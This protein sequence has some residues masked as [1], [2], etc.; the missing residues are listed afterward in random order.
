MN[1]SLAQGN[2]A[3]LK[4]DSRLNSNIDLFNRDNIHHLQ[5]PDTEAGHYAKQYLLPLIE[6]SPA[7]FIGNAVTELYVL[8]ID[9]QV[10]PLTVNCKEYD[11]SYVCSPY[12]HYVTYAKQELILLQN[13]SLE[14]ALA[15]L[16]N[17]VGVG[18][19][20]GRLNQSVHINNWLL[21][22]NLCVE[23]TPVQV[24]A[25]VHFLLKKF[26]SH[27]LAWRSLNR[28]T[29][30]S[31]TNCLAGLGCRLVPSR[32]I[33]LLPT[34]QKEGLPS[35]AR[36]LVKRDFNLI[37]KNN[38]S[39]VGPDELDNTDAPRLVE[40]YNAL[41]LDKYSYCNPWFN[42]QFLGLALQERLLE[43]YALRHN[44]TGSIDAVLGYY[45]REGVM[46]T[47]IFGYDTK[48]PQSIGLYR[49]LSAALIRLALHHGHL[50]HESSGA[51]QFKRN[52][53]A[54]STI[55]YT[56]VYDRHLP[57]YR[58]WG[59]SLLETVLNRIGVPMMKKYKF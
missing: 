33:Y 49:M 35:K 56:A 51:A 53:G 16:L 59:W 24:Q 15:N 13:R 44:E 6:H 5:W 48:L 28:K 11:N 30:K 17:G 42:E 55:E 32:Q 12:T 47:P 58:R 31:L 37:E 1:P 40:L 29:A 39:I 25:I 8:L 43:I 23:L 19:K 9:G 41:Y 34:D 46:T 38:Y 36:W 22:T 54:S 20:L 26:P 2:C 27:S 57:A 4:G 45:F 3:V 10:I 18:L 14:W 21:S 50:L 52:R 7:A